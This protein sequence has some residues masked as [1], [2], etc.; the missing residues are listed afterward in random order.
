MALPWVRKTAARR[1]PRSCRPSFRPGLLAL[2][3]RLAPAT[4]TVNGAADINAADG[5]LTLREAVL[6]ENGA[7]DAT[8]ALGRNLTAPEA[9][10][11]SDV[12]GS[13]DTIQ[14]DPSL[15]G[16]TITLTGS[17]LVLSKSL[18]VVG[19][20]ASLL[21]VNGNHASGVFRVALG[22]TV[23]LSGLTIANGAGFDFGHTTQ[24]GGIWNDG[25]LTVSNSTVASNSASS[26]GGGIYN[27]L[28]PA[29]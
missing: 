25:T 16:R 26:E 8:A 2:E 9:A 3:D 24:G 21:T 18:N 6:L 5:V 22:A 19:P 11:V 1:A 23:S 14:F 13:N 12:F 20:G 29:R 28:L 17:G 15:N 27:D 7:G 4:L 10:Q